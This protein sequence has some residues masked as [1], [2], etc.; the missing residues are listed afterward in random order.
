M[1]KNHNDEV[2]R[3]FYLYSVQKLK[4][5]DKRQNTIGDTK[6]TI[7]FLDFPVTKF[8]FE[9]TKGTEDRNK[10]GQRTLKKKLIDNSV[11]LCR[12]LED[13]SQRFSPDIFLDIF[14]RSRK[15]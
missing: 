5:Y 6:S 4:F 2:K 10:T 15:T 13:F 8:E 11:F 9:R 3:S 14:I 7:I 1:T 12:V